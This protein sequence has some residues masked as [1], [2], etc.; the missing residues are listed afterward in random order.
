MFQFTYQFRPDDAV[1]VV[2]EDENAI[3]GGKVLQVSMKL[4]RNEHT[5][6]YYISLNNSDS[7]SLSQERVFSTISDAAAF[8]ESL[9]S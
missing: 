8:V 4:Y 6:R 5:L 7:I 3:E 9:I 1:Y 2:T